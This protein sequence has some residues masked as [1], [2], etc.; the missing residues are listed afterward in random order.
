M[1]EYSSHTKTTIGYIKGYLKSYYNN[2]ATFKK[3]KATKRDKCNITDAVCSLQQDY[4]RA[5]LIL[6]S[7]TN[8][9]KAKCLEENYKELAA[10]KNELV[11]SFNFVKMHLPTHYKNHV[12]R[13]GSIPAFSTEAGESAHRRQV[14]D[15]Y[16]ASNHQPGTFYK[17]IISYYTRVSAMGIHQLNVKQLVHESYYKEETAD[18]L[19]LMIDL[20]KIH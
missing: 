1:T 18:V 5:A 17:Q 12:R 8:A 14:K 13:F 4:E 3:Y 20:G 16:R 6:R 9:A 19:D 15:G 7:K 11:G 10:K 2:K